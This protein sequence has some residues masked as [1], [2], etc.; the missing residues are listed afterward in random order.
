MNLNPEQQ[1]AVETTTG[2]VMIIAG[3]G[4]GKTKTLTSRILRLIASGVSPKKIL[5]VT[6]TNKAAK[7]MKERIEPHLP[8]ASGM[9]VIGTF[10]SLGVMMLRQFGSKLNIARSFSILDR[11]DQTKLLEESIKSIGL[12]TEDWS[13]RKFK[14][15]ISW[16]RSNH[17]SIEELRANAQS[18]FDT[19]TANVWEK[20]NALKQKQQSLDFDDLLDLPL[21]LLKKHADVREYYQTTFE[22][23]H[24]DEYQDTNKV[25][26]ELVGILA[27]QHGNVCVVGDTDQTIYTWR[28]AQVRNMLLFDKK[29]PQVNMIMLTK[30]YRSTQTILEAGNAMILKNKA[31]IHKDLISQG[32]VGDKILS[33]SAYSEQEEARWVIENF[34]KIH[35]L[36]VKYNDMCVL[37]RSHF[38]SRAIEEACMR[39]GI[40][41]SVIGTKFF[42]R[43]EVKDVIAWI[44]AS[45]NRNSLSDLKRVVEFPKRGVG[46]VAWATICAEQAHTLKAT[47]KTGWEKINSILDEIQEASHALPVS[48]LVEFAAK[49][50]GIWDEFVN[51]TE[52]DHERLLNVQELIAYAKDFTDID[53][54]VTQLELFLERIALVSDQDA[55][56]SSD[57][58][59][60]QGIKL[61]TIHAA[62]GLE[63]NTVAIVGLEE[64]VFPADNDDAEDSEEERRLMYV[65]ITRAK[66]RLLLSWAMTRRIFGSTSVQTPS[67]FLSDIPAHLIQ[68][69]KRITSNYLNDDYPDINI[70]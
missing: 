67:E 10:H 57:N 56:A 70:W 41:Y 12:D 1:Q 15:R 9:P 43:K 28:G 42:E 35:N 2:A 51:G 66:E 20:Y 49:K 21:Q 6:F 50:S 38:L 52:D 8:Y 23:I 16:L 37:Y 24:I 25:Q 68:S 69:E 65:A 7:E 5:A 58:E 27:E 55:L 36:G 11:D 22:Y 18:D 34:T 39:A 45:I 47:A 32:V 59:N 19:F 26:D 46:K 44:R 4:T 13:A 31:R 33:Y 17:T 61:M 54:D 30:N 60:E 40:P 64:G 48:D 29:F 63:F 14:E 62:K 53:E 3:A